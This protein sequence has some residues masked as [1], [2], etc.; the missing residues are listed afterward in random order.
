MQSEFSPKHQQSQ[1][2][3]RATT[4]MADELA[5]DKKSLSDRLA[6]NDNSA[7]KEPATFLTLAIELRQKILAHTY[8]LP[9]LEENRFPD[10]RNIRGYKDD[11]KKWHWTLK[12]VNKQ[13]SQDMDFV[14]S[15]WMREL[16]ELR[17]IREKA[18]EDDWGNLV[19]Y[20]D[21]TWVR[22][23]IWRRGREGKS[24]WTR[25]HS[26]LFE[27]NQ[28]WWTMLDG[29]KRWR[30]L[31][32]RILAEDQFGE[33]DDCFYLTEEEME[34]ERQK[35]QP[36]WDIRCEVINGN[37]DSKFWVGHASWNRG[38]SGI[39]WDGTGR[40]HAPSTWD[41][42]ELTNAAD[43]DIEWLENSLKEYQRSL[44]S[45]ELSSRTFVFLGDR[46]WK[47]RGY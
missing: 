40:E 36:P 18:E 4:K 47:Y 28:F 17:T 44:S 39:Q 20:F 30:E 24:P 16:M 9:K 25:V 42:Q 12:G 27:L 23:V 33:R 2:G 26:Y 7:P 21:A 6:V 34:K 22:E 37:S 46:E 43:V 41:Q 31:E 15:Q 29:Q 45:S 38:P 1:Q 10:N 13:F 32:G 11:V 5:I 19:G 8:E 35:I 14:A 3:S